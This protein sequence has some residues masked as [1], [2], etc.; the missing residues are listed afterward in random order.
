MKTIRIVLDTNVLVSALLNPAGAPSTLL[1]YIENEIITLLLDERILMEYREVLHRQ[2]FKF[3]DG[4]IDE[5][6][7]L[8]DRLGEF[9]FAAHLGTRIPDPDDIPFLEVALSGHADALVTGNKKDYG[10][11]QANL[12]ILSPRECIDF[13]KSHDDIF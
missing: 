13:L 3:E 1:R 5:T 11:V 6:M 10:K 8:L 2:K 9:I 4:L 7:A 12:S